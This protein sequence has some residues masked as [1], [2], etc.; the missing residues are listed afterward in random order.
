MALLWGNGRLLVGLMMYYEATRDRAVLEAARRLAE[1]LLRVREATKAP[2]V[3]KRVEGQGAFGFICFTQ[4]AEGLAML[5]RATGDQRYAEAPKSSHCC[6]HEAC[7]TRTATCRPFAA[8]SCSTTPAR[9]ATCSASRAALRRPRPLRRL[10]PRRRRHGVVRLDRPGNRKLLAPAQD[11]SGHDPRNEGCGLADF[12]RLSLQLHGVTGQA[13]YLERAERCLVNGFDHNQ[14]DNGDFGSRVFFERGIKPTPSVDRAWWCCTMH[15]YRAYR[16]LLDY[17]VVEKDGVLRVQLFEDVDFGGTHSALTVRRTPFGVECRFARRFDGTLEFRQPSWASRTSLSL[18]A[19]PLEAPAEGGF[20]RVQRAFAEGETIPAR[21]DYRLRYLGPDE[22]EVEPARSGSEAPAQAALYC[23]PWLMVVDEAID[24]Y[25][26]GEPWPENVVTLAGRQ[27]ACGVEGR[28][29]S[30][31]PELRA[32]RL[33]RRDAGD[34]A[35]D[36]RD[37][38]RRTE[39]ARLAAQLPPRSGP[40]VARRVR[41]VGGRPARRAEWQARV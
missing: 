6:S 20:L 39:D 32:R 5:A 26:F 9:R 19:R 23:G 24:R 4:L 7:S 21:F 13:D 29:R 11:A 27:H 33:P 17:A 15:G 25:F 40:R 18:N 8:P 28:S 12:V 14:F 37:T 30:P 36:G 16:D 2:A 10:H 1:F 22:C 35:S 31:L 41:C 34:V 38:G 3:M